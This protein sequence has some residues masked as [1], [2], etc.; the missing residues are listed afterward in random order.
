[1]LIS[2]EG[3]R[4]KVRCELAAQ[5]QC[6]QPLQGDISVRGVV[7]FKDHRRDLDNVLKPLLDAL[8]GIAYRNDRQIVH[9][10]FT[11]RLDRGNP[12]VELWIEP[13]AKVEAA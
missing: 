5:A 3:R 4:F 6:K 10:D 13:V 7:Y 11:K 2:E 9:L 12:R 8:Q 1:V